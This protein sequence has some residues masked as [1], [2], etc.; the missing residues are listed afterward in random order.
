MPS[1]FK[2]YNPSASELEHSWRVVDADG[3]VLGRL[4]SEI[5]TVLMGK[6]KAGYVPHMASGDFVIVINASKIAL[7]GK[8]T[9]QK[10]YRRHSQ[11]PGNLKE[12]PFSTNARTH[13]RTH[14]RA[15]SSR[16]AAQKQTRTQ[17]AQ[18]VEGL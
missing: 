3:K 12:I 16:N 4:A 15:S 2:H 9:D 18:Q 17:D 10:V 7:T 11:Y 13:T 6:H 5:A 14:H 1:K 8:K